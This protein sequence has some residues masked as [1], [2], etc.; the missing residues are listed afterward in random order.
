MAVTGTHTTYKNLIENLVSIRSLMV[1][2]ILDNS[3]R[4]FKKERQRKFVGEKITQTLRLFRIKIFQDL[5]AEMQFAENDLETSEEVFYAL[6][7]NEGN[8][9]EAG[10][11]EF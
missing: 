4:L 11:R 6:I 5:S 7:D 10:M 3:R 1:Q 9:T 8:L 2:D